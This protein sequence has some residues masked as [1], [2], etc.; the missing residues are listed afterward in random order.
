MK[1]QSSITNVLY[2]SIGIVITLIVIYF[3]YSYLTN[4]SLKTITSP[5]VISN[6][7]LN[8]FQEQTSGSCS[9]A[10]SFD[11]N[12]NINL[13]SIDAGFLLSNGEYLYPGYSNYTQTTNF[14]NAGQ[15]LY[16]LKPTVGWFGYNGTV[17]KFLS[18]AITSK[19][20]YIIGMTRVIDNKTK[21]FQRFTGNVEFL[22]N[23]PNT[24]PQDIYGD[25]VIGITAT[26]NLGVVII[27]GITNSTFSED[28]TPGTYIYLPIGK[29]QITYTSEGS[30]A[31]FLEWDSDG[32][33]LIQNPQYQQTNMTIINNGQII[34]DNTL[35]IIPPVNFNITENQTETLVGNKVNVTADYVSGYYTFYVNK[36]PYSGCVDT[37]NKT[38]II[39][40]SS[41]GT[42]N[43]TASYKSSTV[44]GVS[45]KLQDLFYSP[46]SVSLIGSYSQSTS[47]VVLSATAS[48][49]Y[50]AITYSFYYANGTAINGCQDISS[51]TCSFT[52]TIQ[53][54]IPIQIKNSASQNFD[55]TNG[56]QVYLTPNMNSLAFS[57]PIGE[58][59]FFEG[60]T[61]LYS[62]CEANCNT[63]NPDVWVDIPGGIGAG[64]TV[65]ITLNGTIE[66]AEGYKV[67][68]FDSSGTTSNSASVNEYSKSYSDFSGH[69]GSSSQNNNIGEVMNSGLVYNIYYDS[70]GTCDSSD[71]FEDTYSSSL[72][73]GTSFTGCQTFTA[74]GGF[75]F[76]TPSGTNN[77]PVDVQISTDTSVS[78][79]DENNVLFNN[80]TGY[81]C[82][83][84]YW[85]TGTT[86]VPNTGNSWQLKAIGWIVAPEEV[87]TTARADDGINISYIGGISNDDF[88]AWLGNYGNGTDIANAWHQDNLQQSG[89]FTGTIPAGTSRIE[90]NYFEDGGQTYLAFFTNQAV[91]YYSPTPYPDNIAPTITPSSF[92]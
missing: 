35:S 27:K 92:V 86:Y 28:T 16:Y 89:P 46:F 45:N 42:Y 1:A 63:N 6:F 83:N 69:M 54:G 73:S 49:G 65:T 50:G 26:H 44:Y 13:A 80:Q 32:G 21:I 79:T 8:N 57:S 17:C 82:G 78:C 48:G 75:L 33:V 87:Q 85:G 39:T 47:T 34:I 43:I 68:A 5:F 90:I 56:A 66:K 2:I 9:F 12:Q 20:N 88:E 14:I 25:S 3:L 15:Y 84:G 38:C 53:G 18:T 7:I 36:L 61:E 59:R 24:N 10:I 30:S 76:T 77:N 62:W 52:Q 91:N 40:E 19:S 23:T 74:N 55:G 58:D 22:V 41:P 51:S 4:S 60:S 64:S 70:S 67:S 81:T 71:Y 37:P 31:I 72:I 29:Y 11:A